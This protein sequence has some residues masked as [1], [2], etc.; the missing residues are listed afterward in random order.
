VPEWI[1]FI[2]PPRDNFAATM[3]EDEKV[4][5]GLAFRAAA[6]TAG[7]WDADPGWT[8]ARHHQHGCGDLQGPDEQAARQLMEQDPAISSG[9]ARGE[10]HPFRVSL[11]RER[12]AQHD[13]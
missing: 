12:P 5:L 3:T 1:Y 4:G 11:L 13:L 8:H 2:H 9:Y 10:L 6:A 7:R